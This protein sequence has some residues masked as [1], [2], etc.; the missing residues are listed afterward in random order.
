VL[1][2]TLK[3]GSRIVSHRFG[4]GDWEP[5]K[6]TMVKGADGDEYELLLWVVPEKKGDK[7]K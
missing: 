3:P 7:N 4:L 6:K 2:K 1:Q 5:T